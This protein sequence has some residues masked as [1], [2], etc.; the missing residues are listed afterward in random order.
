MDRAIADGDEAGYF[1]INL[2]FHDRIAEAAGSER[3]RALYVALGQEVRLMRR[4][5]LHGMPALHR[6]NHEHDLIVTAIE[7]GDA[8]AARAAGA[9]HHE[10]GKKRL[11][12]TL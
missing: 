12:D 2:A 1:E 5:V 4:R 6:S 7:A 10:K 8:D 3:A 9:G 11:L